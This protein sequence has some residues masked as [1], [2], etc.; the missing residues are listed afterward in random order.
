M[1]KC[2][3]E[4]PG[5]VSSSTNARVSFTLSV[6]LYRD[7]VNPRP[8]MPP[9]SPHRVAGSFGLNLLSLIFFLLPWGRS[10]KR[11]D[12]VNIP[13]IPSR[14]L[15]FRRHSVFAGSPIPLLEVSINWQE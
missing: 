14:F 1:I 2:V 7:L 3:R 12:L 4:L 6:Y 9:K 13:E 10:E 5:I 11:E 8:E 15:I